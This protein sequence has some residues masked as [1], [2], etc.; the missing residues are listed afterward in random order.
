MLDFTKSTVTF[1]LDFSDVL[2]FFFETLV[3][4]YK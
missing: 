2:D 4:K 1:I 3:L